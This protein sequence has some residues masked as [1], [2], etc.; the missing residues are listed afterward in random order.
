VKRATG[1]ALTGRDYPDDT[2][3]RP[4]RP[5]K[6]LPKT[7][8]AKAAALSRMK[9][10]RA[11]YNDFIKQVGTTKDF[12]AR[13]NRVAM[14]QA[15]QLDMDDFIKKFTRSLGSS[16]RGGGGSDRLGSKTK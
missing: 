15:G 14:R 10:A 13:M 3:Y 1:R 5:K 4:A 7:P 6:P 8:K 12:N 9:E 2:E 11:R 16:V